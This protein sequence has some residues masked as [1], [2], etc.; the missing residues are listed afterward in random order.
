MHKWRVHLAQYHAF[1]TS[2][3]GQSDL[4]AEK[5]TVS[6]PVSAR[7]QCIPVS[8]RARPYKQHAHTVWSVYSL[9]ES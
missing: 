5:C 9:V 6:L 1:H 2:R 3:S 8:V 4:L 7:N